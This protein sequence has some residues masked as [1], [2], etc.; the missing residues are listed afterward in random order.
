MSATQEKPQPLFSDAE[1]ENGIRLVVWRA[2]SL[3]RMP[4]Y[5]ER[6]RQEQLKLFQKRLE[7]LEREILYNVRD[8]HKVLGFIKALK[9]QP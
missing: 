3:I 2:L 8:Y 9:E 6:F 4:G 7:Y 5:Q 1:D